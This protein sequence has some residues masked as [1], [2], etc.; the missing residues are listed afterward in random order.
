M[1]RSMRQF[2]KSYNATRSI[3]PDIRQV[4]RAETMW[5]GETI[6]QIKIESIGC[7]YSRCLLTIHNAAKVLTGLLLSK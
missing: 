5:Y 6:L 4:S 1:L 3:S 7:M 2:A